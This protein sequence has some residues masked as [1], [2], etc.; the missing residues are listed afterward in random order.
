MYSG[1]NLWMTVQGNLCHQKSVFPILFLHRFN[2]PIIMLWVAVS[3]LLLAIPGIPPH[4]PYRLNLLDSKVA[5]Y[6]ENNFWDHQATAVQY[7]SCCKVPFQIP[8]TIPA[9]TMCLPLSTAHL[10][11]S[12]IRPH[13]WNQSCYF[14]QLSGL[15]VECQPWDWDI[16]GLNPK[17]VIPK[18]LKWYPLCPCLTFST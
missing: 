2:H 17:R 12:R 18:T 8:S 9:T 15:L 7:S 10:P 11:L 1:T 14:Y 5:K 3:T 16:V 13:F 4:S 6:D